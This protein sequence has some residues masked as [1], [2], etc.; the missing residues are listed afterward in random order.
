MDDWPIHTDGVELIK[1]CEGFRSRAY[2][3]PAGV[4][5][6]GWGATR[7]LD[8]ARVTKDTPDV[9]EEEAS[10]I[11]ARDLVKFAASVN[12]LVTVPIGPRQHAALTSF[13]FNL[14]AGQLKCSTLLRKVNGEEWEDVPKEFMKWVMGGGR[15]LPGLQKRRRLEVQLWLEEA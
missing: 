3:C 15:V 12:R 10:R 1:S 8:G 9:D 7:D 6:I 4:W 2:I 5:T 11:L 13:A 14:G